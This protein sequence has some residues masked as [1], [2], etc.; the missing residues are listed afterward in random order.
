LTIDASNLKRMAVFASVVEA[1]SFT[2]AARALGLTRSA[3]SRQVA[4][5]ERGLGVRLLNRTTRRLRLTEAGE[6]YYES[7]AR[8]LAEARQAQQAVRQLHDRPMGTLRINAPVIG[9]RILV[10]ALQEFM[11]LYPEIRVDLSLEDPYVDLLQEGI[12]VAVRI[13][14]P[15]DSSLVARKLAPVRQVVCGSAGYF[16]ERGVPANPRDLVGHEWVI[17]SLLAT[18]DRFVFVKGASRQT[19]RVSGRLRV[20]GGPAMRDALLAGLGLT[21]MPEFYVAD[22]LRQGRLQ[23]VLL[24]YEVKPSDIYAVFPHREHLPGK[25]RLFVDFLVRRVPRLMGVGA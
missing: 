15:T 9:H 24:D 21:L 4:Q 11:Q 13:G 16:E 7:C 6:I 20:N 19:V 1:S 25:V 18:P 5:L 12:D 22:D 17:Y 10:A 23:A 3:V 2:G 8:I 14:H